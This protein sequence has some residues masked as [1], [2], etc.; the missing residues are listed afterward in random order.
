M[1]RL[2]HSAAKS[3]FTFDNS[4]FTPKNTDIVYT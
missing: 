1:K 3:G 2:G 4:I